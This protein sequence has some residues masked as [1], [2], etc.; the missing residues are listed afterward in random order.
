YNIK[1]EIKMLRRG[2]AVKAESVIPPGVAGHDPNYRSSIA[3][4]PE[5]AEKLLDRFGYRKGA[6]GFRTLPDGKPLTLKIHMSASGF[7]QESAELWKR[8]MD[9]IGIR[10]E[11]PVS[12]FADNLK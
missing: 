10:T 8:S 4:E 9:R 12:N 7:A 1:D 11:F 2:Q 5:L 6:D 3:Y